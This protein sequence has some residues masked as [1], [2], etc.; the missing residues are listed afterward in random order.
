[1]PIRITERSQPAYEV[2]TTLQ[3]AMTRL[4]ARYPEAVFSD[5]EWSEPTIW[6]WPSNAA[7]Q[8]ADPEEAIAWLREA[9]GALMPALPDD[10]LTRIETMLVQQQTLLAAVRGIGERHA[11]QQGLL[12]HRLTALEARLTAVQQTLAAIKDMLERGDRP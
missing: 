7:S 12:E 9:E 8:N 1:M 3:E 11:M 2:A 10:R 5:I 6:V 4:V